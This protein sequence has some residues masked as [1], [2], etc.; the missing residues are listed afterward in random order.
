MFFYFEWVWGRT[1]CHWEDAESKRAYH[2][3]KKSLMKVFDEKRQQVLQCRS[4]WH[5]Y[6]SFVEDKQLRK[7]KWNKKYEKHRPVFWDDTNILSN[8]QPSSADQQRLAYLSY[9]GENCAKGSVFIQ[10]SGWI[11]AIRALY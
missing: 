8:Y 5:V 3:N 9:Y 4:S 11:G 6:L 10:L 7:E 1:L 2:L